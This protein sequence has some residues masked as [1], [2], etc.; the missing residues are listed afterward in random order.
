MSRRPC[1]KTA[2]GLSISSPVQKTGALNHEP[3]ALA[4][5]CRHLRADIQVRHKLLISC[6]S[7]NLLVSIALPRFTHG[8]RQ[9]CCKWIDWWSGVLCQTQE[10]CWFEYAPESSYSGTYWI[11]N[12]HPWSRPLETVLRISRSVQ[13]CR[14]LAGFSQKVLLYLFQTTVCIW[15]N[16][17][18]SQGLCQCS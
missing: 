3:K 6:P 18:G 8:E 2:H 9:F 13:T 4:C 1:L 7:D 11:S 17:R 16:H 14:R 5:A 15:H 10:L 12:L